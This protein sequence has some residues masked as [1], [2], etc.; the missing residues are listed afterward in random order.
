MKREQFY[1]KYSNS[2]VSNLELERKYRQHI[3]EQEMME[4]SQ[5]TKNNITSPV[6]GTISPSEPEIEPYV[7]PDYVDDDYME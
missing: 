4:L 2:N 3:F 6:A 1:K 7:D 5:F